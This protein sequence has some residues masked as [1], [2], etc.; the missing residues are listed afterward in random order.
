M[1]NIIDLARIT[2]IE[3]C[4]EICGIII[5]TWKLAILGELSSQASQQFIAFEI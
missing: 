4:L 2:F 5:V 1:I 3:S